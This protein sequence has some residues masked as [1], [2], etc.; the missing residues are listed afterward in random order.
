MPTAEEHLA[1]VKSAALALV[2]RE[3]LI[4]AVAIIVADLPRHPDFPQTPGRS[5]QFA[6]G[7][8][9]ALPQGE[10][11]VRAWIEGIE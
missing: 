4:E 7:L 9:E 11:A 1:T 10:A 2:E 5:L 8:V 3:R 6:V